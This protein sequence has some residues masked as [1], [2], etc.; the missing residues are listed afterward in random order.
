MIMNM[1]ILIGENILIRGKMMGNV[2]SESFR[3][4]MM[5]SENRAEQAGFRVAGTSSVTGWKRAE[6]KWMVHKGK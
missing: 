2:L 4:C 5:K 1:A 3:R 6:D